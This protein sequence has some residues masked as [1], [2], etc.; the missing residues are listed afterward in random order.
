MHINN[1]DLQSIFLICTIKKHCNSC[2]S[3]KSQKLGIRNKSRPL[4]LIKSGF[5]GHIG[6]WCH[7]KTA[8][9]AEIVEKPP[10]ISCLR[11]YRKLHSCT[12]TK[13]FLH[14]NS[15][16]ALSKNSVNSVKSVK[17]PI[18]DSKPQFARHRE[19]LLPLCL[20]TRVA[21]VPVKQGMAICC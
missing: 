20:F 8:E 16:P 15:H 1:L 10:Y 18:N 11:L 7:Q 6:F 3:C 14:S 2:K 5:S 4:H 21:P 9:I 17:T 12:L 13:E 19:P